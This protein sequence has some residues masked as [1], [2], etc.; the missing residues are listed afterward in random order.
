VSLLPFDGEKILEKNNLTAAKLTYAMYAAAFDKKDVALQE[1]YLLNL[2]NMNYPDATVYGSLARIQM[3]RGNDAEA[4]QY[5]NRGLEIKPGDP[6]LVRE[7]INFYIKRNET[8]KLLAELTEAIEAD[9]ENPDN[10]QYYSILGNL[11]E[12]TKDEEKAISNYKKAI[13]LDEYSY[14]AHW[15]LGAIYITKANE[16]Y[17]QVGGGVSMKDIEPKMKAFYKEA[18]P[19]LERASE[20][21]NYSDSDKREL[22]KNL[23]RIYDNLGD[24]VNSDRVAQMIKDLEG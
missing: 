13:E 3:D 22:Y 5:I 21:D 10:A 18:K 12:Q 24:K 16:L 17:K 8:D 23:K 20:N 14:D 4:L 1:K 15:N 11:Y 19:H 2:V 9:P 6:A 7:K